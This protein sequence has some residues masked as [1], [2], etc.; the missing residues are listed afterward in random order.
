MHV[1]TSLYC[2][3]L[4]KKFAVFKG[5]I[6]CTKPRICMPKWSQVLVHAFILLLQL[7]KFI[8]PTHY[9]T[10]K[11]LG[12]R[13]IGHVSSSL[14]VPKDTPGLPS[15]YLAQWPMNSQLLVTST[16]FN[17]LENAYIRQNI[18]GWYMLINQLYELLFAFLINFIHSYIRAEATGC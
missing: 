9:G 6:I 12:S 15:T 4:S 5:Y 16:E 3:T 13:N 10:P 2:F 1:R 8:E 18:I 11:A 14:Y 17:L 7:V